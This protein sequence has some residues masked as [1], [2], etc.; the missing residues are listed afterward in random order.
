LITKKLTEE[1]AVELIKR[2]RLQI[3]IHACIYYRLN[4][5]VIS[6]HQ[7]DQWAKELAELQEKYPSASA[8]APYAKEFE[9]F[10]IETTSA[11][12]LPIHEPHI[13]GKAQYI[14]DLHKKILKD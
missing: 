8:R 10:G 13:V 2:R 4:D 14:L 12:N 6:D 9:G 5:N 11:F 7:Y 1:Q 3:L